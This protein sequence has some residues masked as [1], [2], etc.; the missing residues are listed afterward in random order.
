[1]ITLNKNNYIPLND[2]PKHHAWPPIGGLRHL[3]CHAHSNGFDKVICRVGRRVLIN[4]DAF[5]KWLN[6]KN[7]TSSHG[8]NS[9]CN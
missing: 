2:W 7:K 1:M 3:V 8:E 9:S 5:F 6:N 4:E